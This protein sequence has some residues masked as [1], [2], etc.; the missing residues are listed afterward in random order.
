MKKLTNLFMFFIAVLMIIGTVALQAQTMVSQWGSTPRGSAWPILNTA[1]TPAGNAGMG[2]DAAPTAWASIKGGFD[3]MTPTL[4]QAVVIS[5][6]F[7]FV[8]GG[9]GSAYTWLRY[10]FFYQ[11]P[12]TLTN[13]NT[14]TAAWSGANCWG[15]QFDPRS[16][17]GTIANA[18]GGQGTLWTV[19]GSGGWNSSY[20]NGKPLSTVYNAPYAAVAS[21]GVYDWAISVRPLADG[22]N[23]IRYYFVKQH[24]PDKQADYW[25]AGITIDPTPVTTKFNSI[26]FSVNNDIDKTCKQ[27]NLTNVT[28][29]LGDPIT[30]PDAPFEA[31]YVDQ[32]GST[33]RGSSGWTIL[34]DSTYIVGDA[35]MGGSAKPTGWMSIKGGFRETVTATVKKAL[36]I[37]GS[38]EFVGGGAGS[39]YTWLRFALFNE[40]GKLSN[41][42]MPNAMWSEDSNGN[43][44]IFTPVSGTG[45]VS[46][47]YNTWPQG[48]S[49]TEW[50]LIN[51]KGW[52]STNSNGG[53]P[54]STIMQAPYRA[55]ATAGVYDWAISV[56]PLA[57]GTQEV[58]WYF[59]KQHAAGQQPTYWWGGSFI[60]PT[61]ATSSFNS[62]GFAC[63]NDLDATCKQVNLTNVKVDLTD[64]ITVPDAPFEAFYVDQW[65]STPRGSS[66]WTILNDSTYVVGDASMGGTGKPTGWMSIKGG[67]RE[68][69]KPNLKKAMVISGTFEFVGGG[70]GSAYTWLRFALFNGAGK[71]SNQ[72]MPNAMWSEDSNGNGYIFTPVSGTG[73]VSNTYNTWPQGNSGTEW[74]LINSKGWT[75]TNSNGGGPYSTIF[76]AP[77]RAVATAGVYDWAISVQPL[78]DGTQE[79]RWYFIQKHAAGSTNYYWWGGSFIDALPV[80]NAFNSIG[81]AINNDVDATLKQV[82]LTNVKVDLTDPITVPD[83]PWQSYYVDQWGFFGGQNGASQT[84]TWKFVPADLTGNA[85]ITGAKPPIN[86]ASL[87]GGWATPVTPKPGKAFIV[88]GKFELVG[89][90]FENWGSLN[91]GLFYCPNPGK[92]DSTGGSAFT[93][94]TG[95][96]NNEYGYLFSPHSDKLPANTYGLY[97]LATV[98]AIV[99]EPWLATSGTSPFDKNN[100]NYIVSTNIQNPANAVGTAGVYNFAFSVAPQADGTNEIRYSIEKADKSYNFG[101][102]VIDKKSPAVVT[103]FNSINFAISNTSATAMK[104]TDV[105]VDLGNPITIPDSYTVTAVDETQNNQLPTDYS[106]S[107]NYP[108]PF[109]PTT[110]IEFALPKNGY[111][112]LVVYDLMGRVV[113]QLVDGVLNAGYHKVNFNGTNLS[114]G[115]Y[116]YSL[117]ADNFS[118]VKK[119]M[120]LK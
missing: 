38:F 70:G 109:N 2:A 88:S 16:G 104:V 28:V 35:A 113:S 96:D 114:S 45:T 91:L 98:G 22:T 11:D 23:E 6:T 100:G 34:N 71:L 4:T 41:Q 12:T 43:G 62:I 84:S 31:F 46:N 92:I 85:T 105:M 119:L 81:F 32:W 5:G 108:N 102:I 10:A 19:V 26:A 68:T 99:N 65:G 53:G 14:P 47:T 73:T 61:P 89:G 67:F 118:S 52:T 60:D 66:G 20:A 106:L 93:H 117:K 56:Q 7:E 54:Y 50:P 33:P 8:G 17:N 120:L 37:S 87:R 40:S 15:Y 94:W 77:Y 25:F 58:R 112:K 27:V 116:F 76:Q 21:A 69:V 111:V 36:V 1:S 90:G 44:Y 49:G 101:G 107:Q 39:A 110:N 55:V 9:G 3:T 82:N 30:I 72:N 78:A 83:A 103:K 57:N 13:Q 42:N 59:V 63:N 79:V 64:P 18:G 86:W 48:N 80:T 51:S 115:V 24:A 97:D 74:P 95:T 75:S 29:K